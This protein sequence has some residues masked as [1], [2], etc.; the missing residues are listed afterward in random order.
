[1]GKCVNDGGLL[2]D[3]PCERLVSGTVCLEETL[4]VDDGQAFF[5]D[6]R[7]VIALVA[8][9]ETLKPVLDVVGVLESLFLLKN[10]L[11]YTVSIAGKVLNKKLVSNIRGGRHHR[12]LTIAPITVSD[13]LVQDIQNRSVVNDTWGNSVDSG[14]RVEL[15]LLVELSLDSGGL[16][17]SSGGHLGC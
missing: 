7:G 3:V 14:G 9:S 16:G 1:V 17:H 11:D 8:E 13:R 15:G 5:A 4:L 2:A 10:S 12:E 6:G